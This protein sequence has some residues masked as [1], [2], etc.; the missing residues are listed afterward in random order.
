MKHLRMRN[1][2]L[3]VNAYSWQISWHVICWKL[4]LKIPFDKWGLQMMLWMWPRDFSWKYFLV[5][6]LTWN[7][8]LYINYEDDVWTS[9]IWLTDSLQFTDQNTFLEKRIVTK[10]LKSLTSLIC[11]II[12]PSVIL[13]FISC[14]E[15]RK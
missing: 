15:L 13:N 7:I 12:S 10:L 3:L 4:T 5:C 9:W 14:Q 8:N 6:S 11:Q 1:S 2:L